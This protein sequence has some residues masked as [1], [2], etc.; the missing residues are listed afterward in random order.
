VA[1]A[2][3]GDMI[4]SHLDD[5]FRPLRL[6]F[7]AA[8]TVLHRGSWVDWWYPRIDC[9]SDPDIVRASELKHPVQG[10]GSDGN[11]GCLRP[12]GPGP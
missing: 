12:V 9:L 10:R 3:S 11:L 6:P 4:E 7:A 8:L 5:E 2:I 1:E